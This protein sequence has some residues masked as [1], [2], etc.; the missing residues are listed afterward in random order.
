[1][2]SGG[3]SS[4]PTSDFFSEALGDPDGLDLPEGVEVLVVDMLLLEESLRAGLLGELSADTH[5]HLILHAKGRAMEGSCMCHKYTTITAQWWILNFT[6][7][8]KNLGH[9]PLWYCRISIQRDWGGGG[10]SFSSYSS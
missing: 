8:C 1:M 9:A 10:I 3:L 6:K 5:R 4:L 2:V 7:G